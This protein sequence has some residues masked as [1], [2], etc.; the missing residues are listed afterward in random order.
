MGSAGKY[1][2]IGL[3]LLAFAAFAFVGY[4][5]QL[6]RSLQKNA[7]LIAMPGGVDGGFGDIL[8]T[9]AALVTDPAEALPLAERLVR[10]RP[11]PAAN[12]ELLAIAAAEADQMEK[13]GEALQLAARRGWRGEYTQSAA[14]AGAISVGDYEGAIQRLEGLIRSGSSVEVSANVAAAIARVPEAR[15]FLADRMIESEPFRTQLAKATVT[16][17]SF[18][19]VMEELIKLD[20]DR[21]HDCEFL[22]RVTP[23]LL[24]R[25]IPVEPST[26]WPKRCAGA[27]AD[28]GNFAGLADPYGWR[29]GKARGLSQ[30]SSV[31]R[32]GIN[33]RNRSLVRHEAA[34]RYSALPA[35]SIA[36]EFT[37][38]A[39]SR[40]GQGEANLSMSCVREGRNVPVDAMRSGDLVEFAIPENCP[41]Q[42]LSIVVER[43]DFSD[44]RVER[45]GS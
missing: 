36:Y 30:N 44:I 37:Y 15:P 34:Y 1:L 11:V 41:V 24:A 6:D 43:G 28:Q 22:A 10:H 35:G 21:E 4:N 38:E 26:G 18:T 16:M 2:S 33:I 27:L 14:V 23:A 7:S 40:P 31:W 20:G 8:R 19:A 9:R 32:Q 17:P 29:L 5:V 42:R 3:R 13:A 39:G 45:A 25:G 12:L